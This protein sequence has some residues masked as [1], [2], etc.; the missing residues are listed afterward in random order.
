MESVSL[1]LD[2][3]LAKEMNACMRFGHYSTKTE[4]I[5]ESLRDKIARVREERKKEEA[6]ERLF[7]MR[8]ILKGKEKF[9]TDEE[10]HNW[11]SNVFSK[12][13][14]KELAKKYGWKP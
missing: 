4:F 14:E 2:D 1:K 5:R 7:A 3:A 11:R 9:K 12:Q 8:G 6:W 13:L 10:W